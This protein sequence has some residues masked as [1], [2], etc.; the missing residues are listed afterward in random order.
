MWGD[1][2]ARGLHRVRD[3]RHIAGHWCNFGAIAVPQAQR[4]SRPLAWMS[5]I[6]IPVKVRI[7]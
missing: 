6:A 5:A 2:S 3:G 4:Q 1:A 7:Q